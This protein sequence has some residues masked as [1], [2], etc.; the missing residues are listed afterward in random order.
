[1]PGSKDRVQLTLDLSLPPCRCDRLCQ[2][3]LLDTSNCVSLDEVRDQ[4]HRIFLLE[5]L[6]SYGLVERKRW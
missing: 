4:K 2:E 3:H 6:T 1:M 5:A